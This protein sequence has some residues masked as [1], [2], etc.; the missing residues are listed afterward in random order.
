[1]LVVMLAVGIS[2]LAGLLATFE[3]FSEYVQTLWRKGVEK[4]CWVRCSR[5]TFSDEVGV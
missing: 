5:K 4:K 3:Q 2:T 1:M